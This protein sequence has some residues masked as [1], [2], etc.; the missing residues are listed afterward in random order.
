M[1]NNL[2]EEKNEVEGETN[3]DAERAPEDV[4]RVGRAFHQ[5]RTCTILVDSSSDCAPAVAHRLGVEV[6]PLTYVTPEGERED[7]LW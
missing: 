7:D 4:V 2:Q 1:S 6:I 3:I 5:R